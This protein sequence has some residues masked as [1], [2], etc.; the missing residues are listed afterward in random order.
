MQKVGVGRSVDKPPEVTIF[1]AGVTGLTAAHELIERGF[2][3]HVVEPKENP[4]EEHGCQVGGM[5]ANQLARV[6]ALDPIAAMQIAQGIAASGKQSDAKDELSAELRALIAGIVPALARLEMEPVQTRAPIMQRLRFAKGAKT[7][8]R[9]FADYYEITNKRKL[10]K[11]LKE[12]EQSL[13]E[14]KDCLLY[15]SPSPRD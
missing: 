13:E 5:A 9:E 14:Y 7:D 1:G 4:L 3:V 8:W 6:P 12:I 2:V 11:V 10:E 15:T